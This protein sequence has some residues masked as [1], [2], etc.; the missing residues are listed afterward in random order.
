MILC[1]GECL[2][3]M[4]PVQ[5]DLG[6][7]ALQ[8][9]TGG[10]VFNTAVALGRL[11]AEVGFCSGVSTD[12]FGVQIAD[13]LKKN[14]VNDRFLILSDRPTTLAFVQLENGQARYVFYDENS[15]GR[16]IDIDDFSPVDA[17]V[18][19]LFFGGISLISEPAADA[20]RAF[21]EQNSA[22]RLVYL[23]P[24]IRPGFVRDEPQYRSRLNAMIANADIVKVS[25]EDLFW[26]SDS[27][28]PSSA[29]E[30]LLESGPKLVLLTKGAEGVE[31]YWQGGRVD[32]ATPQAEV[33]DTVGAGDTFNAG[34]LKVLQT[35]NLLHKELMANPDPA[36]VGRALDLGVRAAAVTVSR[37]G[38]N[39]PYS[40]ELS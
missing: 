22:D 30:T 3:D 29:V 28:D 19:C 23:D 15:A 2:I 13:V 40:H 37:A 38:A 36:L 25:D 33:V 32:C 6:A 17:E 1:C 11:D 18:S 34:F 5:S 31:A 26:L 8:P 21:C 16:M 27:G 35:E 20:Y 24:N 4:L 7:D 14:K 10:A 12:L 39:P 9:H